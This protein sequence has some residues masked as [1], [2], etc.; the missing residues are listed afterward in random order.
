MAGLIRCGISNTKRLVG[1]YYDTYDAYMAKREEL[2]MKLKESTGY[3]NGESG[4]A[5][6]L[7]IHTLLY[8]GEYDAYMR[9]MYTIADELEILLPAAEQLCG[10]RES[11]MERIS[12]IQMT[13]DEAD[14]L[15]AEPESLTALADTLR[16]VSSA[17]CRIYE[18]SQEIMG[19]GNEVDLSDIM[20]QLDEI[21]EKVHELEAVAD[22]IDEYRDGM[23]SLDRRVGEAFQSGEDFLR[24]YRDGYISKSGSECCEGQISFPGNEVYETT[25]YEDDLKYKNKIN[26]G[27]QELIELLIGLKDGL[28]GDIYT[29][30]EA[31]WISEY[32]EFNDP[33]Q[34]INVA[35]TNE[36]SPGE[37]KKIIQNIDNKF[38]CAKNYVYNLDQEKFINMEDKHELVVYL[39]DLFLMHG[40]EPEFTAAMIGQLV[41]EGEF[42][43]LENTNYK[44]NNKKNMRDYQIFMNEHYSYLEL[45]SNKYVTEIGIE[46]VIQLFDKIKQ[47]NEEDPKNK[48]LRKFGWGIVQWTEP[49]RANNLLIKYKEMCENCET[50]GEEQCREVESHFIVDELEGKY[51]YD[52]D[53]NKIFSYGEIYHKWKSREVDGSMGVS[54]ASEILFDEYFIGISDSGR[55]EDAQSIYYIMMKD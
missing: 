49:A 34:L 15:Y 6:R 44:G 14:H 17:M 22:D 23:I 47:D 30:Q 55:N 21:R 53:G 40:F 35:I 7:L 12:T 9:S 1:H 5:A 27:K 42:G 37:C 19:V 4:D 32:Y 36:N 26:L 51:D 29:E 46:S 11:I 45:Y 39:A 18:E 20:G 25:G 41:H 2:D 3:W 8:E 31:T 16:T 24:P 50:F 48:N 28:D 54:A 43:L 10:L 38:R 33:Q 13:Q 52:N